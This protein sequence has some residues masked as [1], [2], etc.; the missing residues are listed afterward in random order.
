MTSPQKRDPENAS[1]GQ[2]EA[3]AASK[4]KV[5]EASPPAQKP[6]PQDPAVSL[7]KSLMH[8]QADPGSKE[9]S[10][11]KMVFKGCTLR[12]FNVAGR[13]IGEAR[14][15][16]RA[17][18]TA[19][20]DRE[21]IRCAVKLFET[22]DEL[23]RLL[24]RLEAGNVA[25]V[26]GA[27]ELGA[28]Q[29]AF[30]TLRTLIKED[31]ISEL[32]QVV[33][34]RELQGVSFARGVG[35]TVEVTGGDPGGAHERRS[36]GERLQRA[37][38]FLVVRCQASQ[39]LEHD[40]VLEGWA[41]PPERMLERLVRH[42]VESEVDP[43]RLSEVLG[44]QDVKR[45]LFELTS[46]STIDRL[47]T[48]LASVLDGRSDLH[49]VLARMERSGEQTLLEWF[50][51]NKSIDR[52]CHLVAAAVLDGLPWS[53]V[54]DAARE[55]KS[56]LRPGAKFA[57]RSGGFGL[58]RERIAALI[59]ADIKP[60]QLSLGDLPL[61]VEGVRLRNREWTAR[62]FDVATSR[63]VGAREA[64]LGWLR[65]M[66]LRDNHLLIG[67]LGRTAAF[68]LDRDFPDALQNLLIPWAEADRAVS[69]QAVAE[70]MEH[71]SQIGSSEAAQLMSEV[72][73]TWLHAPSQHPVARTALSVL[74]HSW[75]WR[76]QERTLEL[77]HG[78][79]RLIGVQEL[80]SVV[81][82]LARLVTQSGRP[83]ETLSTLLSSCR[84][85]RQE[86]EPARDANARGTQSTAGELICL[87]LVLV[88]PP[89][90]TLDFMGEKKDL[91]R[92]MN[93]VLA[94]SARR[95]QDDGLRELAINHLL[96][97]VEAAHA[98]PVRQQ[99]LRQFIA[100]FGLADEQFERDRQRLASYLS[101]KLHER[102][103]A[104]FAEELAELLCHPPNIV[105][106][107]H[108]RSQSTP[109]PVQQQKA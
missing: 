78:R 62:A 44:D 45:I 36:L 89:A 6:P 26:H 24:A 88:L 64:L 66:G 98:F 83:G 85:W 27:T 48:G 12:D 31:S 21:S 67:H 59:E 33:A 99:I 20:V 87:A 17:R 93:K 90:D 56:R 60:V 65:E 94:S 2:K 92:Q 35:Y 46:Y 9:G 54:A 15:A 91:F 70:A 38:A 104:R 72:L 100:A 102:P 3:P 25:A 75:G 82:V 30:A 58:H 108:V 41:L 71:Y 52:R 40:V 97:L 86:G 47:A 103:C 14:S 23:S 28:R 37:G 4:S 74:G 16:Q 10:P 34:W 84:T 101:S 55:L 51:K 32:G 95:P 69:R 61:K 8:G 81:D 42:A 79:V 53:V 19:Y 43:N 68:L 18:A 73:R 22:T 7:I 109:H 76:H 13:D 80:P 49:A 105:R 39:P 5:E 11:I 63:F 50:R 57:R 106:G 1:P 29:L 96:A 107:H 77:L